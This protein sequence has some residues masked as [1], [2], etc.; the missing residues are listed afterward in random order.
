MKFNSS[1]NELWLSCSDSYLI[2]I[3]TND[4]HITKN[5]APEEFAITQ[6]QMLATDQIQSIL[7]KKVV[8]NFGIGQT[9]STDRLVFLTESS[10]DSTI[11]IESFTPWK[12]TSIKRFA[13]SSD[14]KILAVLQNDGTINF[15]SMEYLI[16]QAFQ[17]KFAPQPTSVDRTCSMISEN[18]KAFDKNVSCIAEQQ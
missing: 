3:D 17:M 16:R 11:D 8:T 4:W 12:C 5:V 9:N 13:C 2:V 10:N 1:G 18:L 7:H 15:Y 6:L 14:G